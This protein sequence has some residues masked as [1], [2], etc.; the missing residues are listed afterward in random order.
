MLASGRRPCAPSGPQT[1]GPAPH[2]A[3]RRP[4]GPVRGD[5]PRGYGLQAVGDHRMESLEL[6]KPSAGLF[7]VTANLIVF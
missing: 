6:R 7:C 5:A 4:G 2:G 1:E 3:P